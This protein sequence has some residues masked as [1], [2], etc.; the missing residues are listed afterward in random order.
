MLRNSLIL[1]F[2]AKQS[3]S[4]QVIEPSDKTIETF[5][6]S[7]NTEGSEIT[8]GQEIDQES[9]LEGE[10]GYKKKYRISELKKFPDGSV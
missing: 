7:A 9:F 10:K 1:V 8:E 4:I 5:E 2:L 3:Q 6:E